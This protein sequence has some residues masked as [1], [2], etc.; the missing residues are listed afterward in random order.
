LQLTLHYR[1]AAKEIRGVREGGDGRREGGKE[2]RRGRTGEQKPIDSAIS[3][4]NIN[5]TIII[6]YIFNF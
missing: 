6:F 1:Q 3:R 5:T 2:G 4:N